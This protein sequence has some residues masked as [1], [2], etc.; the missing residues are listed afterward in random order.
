[1]MLEKT[2]ES[3]LDS[4]E[5]KPVDLKGDQPWILTGRT[6]VKLKLQYF[7]HLM[8]KK[9]TTSWLVKVPDVGKHQGQKEKRASENE[10]AGWH[11]WLDRRESE[12]TPGVCDGQG[13]LVCCDSWGRKESDTTE[14]LNWTE[15]IQSGLLEGGLVTGRSRLWLEAWNF[16]SLAHVEGIGARNGVNDWLG[17]CDE[18]FSNCGA[19]EDA[20]ESLGQQG[21]QT[22]WS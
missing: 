17:L 15:L 20:W 16:Q 19:G 8:T 10:M 22:S 6:D 5:I 7:G 2:P 18:I 9:L 21:D 3:P 1:M 13:G 14:W 12:W 11:H 4:K